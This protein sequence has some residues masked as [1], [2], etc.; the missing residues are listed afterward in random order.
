[1]LRPNAMY[2]NEKRCSQCELCY[3][4]API[5][6]DN[7]RRIPITST[8]LEAMADCPSGAIQWLEDT[9]EGMYLLSISNP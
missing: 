4:I 6:R 8:T 1:M 7:P 5:I 3:F 9:R 2:L